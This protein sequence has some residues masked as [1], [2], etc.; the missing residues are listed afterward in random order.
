M[1]L[2]GVVL[3]G[4]C[5]IW[6]SGIMDQRIDQWVDSGRTYAPTEMP[7]DGRP[8]FM[9]LR[10]GGGWTGPDGHWWT[11]PSNLPLTTRLG[12][13][14][15]QLKDT[16]GLRNPTNWTIPAFPK[17]SEKFFLLQGLQMCMRMTG[18]RYFVAREAPNRISFSP[19]NTLNG[20]Q[21]VAAFEQ[22]ARDNGLVLLQVS[23]RNVKVIPKN[24]LEEYRKA[25]LI[26][27][28]N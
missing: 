17:D 28:G 14:Y 9:D 20:A 18:K 5:V 4:L 27:R 8:A 22:A 1:V 13:A 24:K 10:R 12:L 16:V 21:W 19:T 15:S 6:W 26:K 23:K 7:D 3:V 11:T 2:L 25:G